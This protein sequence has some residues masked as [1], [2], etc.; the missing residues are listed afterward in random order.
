MDYAMDGMQIQIQSNIHTSG[1][2]SMER[3]NSCG[4]TESKRRMQIDTNCPI[5]WVSEWVSKHIAKCR[6]EVFGLEVFE[7]E[8]QIELPYAYIVLSYSFFIGTIL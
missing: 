1:Y 7:F 5:E 8:F 3:A 4:F 2:Q 6:R